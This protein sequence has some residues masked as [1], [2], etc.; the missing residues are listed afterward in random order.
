MSSFETVSRQW[1]AHLVKA[2]RHCA[3][4]PNVFECKYTLNT[5]TVQVSFFSF[6]F[7][8]TVRLHPADGEVLTEVQA[9]I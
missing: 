3:N 8:T 1:F 2:L 6:S 5:F 9:K 4:D 7:F